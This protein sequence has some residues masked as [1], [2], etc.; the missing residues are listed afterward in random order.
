MQ[1]CVYMY[2]GYFD[3]FMCSIYYIHADIVLHMHI[4]IHACSNFGNIH[5]HVHV[6]SVSYSDFSK[7]MKRERIPSQAELM[8]IFKKLDR[9]GDGCITTS[10]L[11]RL[12]TKVILVNNITCNR[13]TEG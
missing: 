3:Y 12:L 11:K 7:I 1:L 5:V 9:K 4:H 10:D 2:D 6:G 13:C 8:S